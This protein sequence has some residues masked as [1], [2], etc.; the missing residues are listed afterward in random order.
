[1]KKRCEKCGQFAYTVNIGVWGCEEQKLCQDCINVL[2]A[3]CSE[4][5]RLFLAKE[6]VNG[7]CES[8]IEKYSCADCGNFEDDCIWREDE[9]M[10]LCDDCYLERIEENNR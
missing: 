2:F 6:L 4:C 3:T 8:C 5:S 1:M 9:E 10:W 7:V